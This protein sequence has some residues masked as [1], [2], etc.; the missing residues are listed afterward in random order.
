MSAATSWRSALFLAVLMAIIGPLQMTGN[1]TADSAEFTTLLE[2][3]KIRFSTVGQSDFIQLPGDGRRGEAA[4]AA[5][6]PHCACSLTLAC[7]CC[8]RRTLCTLLRQSHY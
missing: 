7:V 1:I 2:A 5:P 3:D 4:R 6:S 8:V